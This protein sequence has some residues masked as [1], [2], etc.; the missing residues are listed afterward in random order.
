MQNLVRCKVCMRETRDAR[1]LSQV[2]VRVAIP[3]GRG[4]DS[5]GDKGVLSLRVPTV[6]ILEAFENVF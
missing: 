5:E 2:A 1:K 3:R 4:R 6:G